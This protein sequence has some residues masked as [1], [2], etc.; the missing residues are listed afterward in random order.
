MTQL[1]STRTLLVL[2]MSCPS[3]L[4]F[5][6]EVTGVHE[7]DTDIEI[8]HPEK[9]RVFWTCLLLCHLS[10]CYCRFSFYSFHSP[11]FQVNKAA[12]GHSPETIQ[13]QMSQSV[14]VDIVKYL[15]VCPMSSE[16]M[17]E[18][19]RD[20][21]LTR[22]RFLSGSGSFSL[23]GSADLFLGAPPVNGEHSAYQPGAQVH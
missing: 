5:E 1:V 10:F 9:I 18:H 6:A 16:P 2:T 17:W 19:S 8:E 3:E 11:H 13:T 23:S 14:A 22:S 7:T 12:F 15:N 20:M 4:G 21:S